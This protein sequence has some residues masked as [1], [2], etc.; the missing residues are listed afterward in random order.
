MK[1]LFSLLLIVFC[2][3]FT[4][5]AYGWV[6]LKSVASKNQELDTEHMEAFDAK[7]FKKEQKRTKRKAK[8]EKRLEKFKAKWEKKKKG[9]NAE[10]K[11]SSVWD[12]TRF[13]I[14]ALLLIGAIGLGILGALGILSGLFNFVGGILALAGII[15]VVW[16]LVTY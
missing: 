15:L 6:P 13:R 10:S 14:G 1:H 3:A 16:A 8:L 2:F 11:T 4:N 5:S 7:A 9:I 12:D